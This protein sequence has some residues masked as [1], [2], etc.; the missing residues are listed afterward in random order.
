MIDDLKVLER[1]FNKVKYE[2]G[3]WLW[4][5]SITDGYGKFSVK[6]KKVRAHRWLYIKYREEI[7]DGLVL[8]HLCRNRNCV[9]PDHLEPV[10]VKENTIRGFKSRK[11]EMR[12]EDEIGKTPRRT[13]YEP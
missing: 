11:Q 4:T 1:F 3:C 5:G 2:D 8:D 9:C 7:D 13:G 12:C 6:G 10:T